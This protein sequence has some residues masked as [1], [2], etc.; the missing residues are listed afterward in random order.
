MHIFVSGAARAFMPLIVIFFGGDVAE[1]QAGT[2]QSEKY[3]EQISGA[4][5]RVMLWGIVSV[6]QIRLSHL[7]RFLYSRSLRLKSV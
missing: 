4:V 1:H 6:R 7:F 2:L 3:A 5:I